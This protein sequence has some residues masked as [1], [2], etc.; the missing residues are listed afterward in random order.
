MYYYTVQF[1]KYLPRSLLFGLVKV[2]NFQQ[3]SKV[4]LPSHSSSTDYHCHAY[5]LY[6]F[7]RLAPSYP[8]F[9]P[10]QSPHCLFSS[11][12]STTTTT[13]YSFIHNHKSR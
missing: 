6:K 5:D 3:P 2:V 10:F 9:N 4:R 13:T 11:L 7:L 12:P 1:L 8:P